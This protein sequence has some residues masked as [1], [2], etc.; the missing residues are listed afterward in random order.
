MKIAAV[1]KD[2]SVEF[3]SF[4]EDNIESESK[5]FIKALNTMNKGDFVT[6]FTPD[7]THFEV[8]LIL[9]NNGFP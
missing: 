8:Q 2:M 6:I 7:D 9:Y 5:A 4:P 1:Y 3:E